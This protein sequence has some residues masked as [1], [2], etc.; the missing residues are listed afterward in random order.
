MLEAEKGK[1]RGGILADEMGLGKTLEI[2]AVIDAEPK[3]P[4]GSCLPS[5]KMF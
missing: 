5:R 3:I 2:L 4:G 1:F